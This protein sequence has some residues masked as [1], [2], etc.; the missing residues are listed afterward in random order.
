MNHPELECRDSDSVFRDL[1]LFHNAMLRL[2]DRPLTDKS[3][4]H[5]TEIVAQPRIHPESNTIRLLVF[6]VGDETYAVPAGE[7]V[8]VTR[9]MQVCI[10]PH[11][12]HHIF[13]GLCCIEGSLVLCASLL[14]LLDLPTEDITSFHDVSNDSRR[15][16]VLGARSDSWA[17][18]VDQVVEVITV[19]KATLKRPPLTVAHSPHHYTQGLVPQKNGHFAALLDVDRILMGFKASLS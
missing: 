2:L 10:V 3:I 4:S 7:V 12:T 13:R 5:A 16:I 15:M 14:H 6:L 9:V 19:E 8:G 1:A 17:V 11:R 18:E